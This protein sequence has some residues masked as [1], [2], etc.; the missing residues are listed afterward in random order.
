VRWARV[1]ANLQRGAFDEAERTLDEE[2]PAGAEDLAGFELCAR[3]EIRLGRGDVEGGLLLWRAAAD[4]VATATGAGLW[5]FEVEAVAV[6]THARFGRLDLVADLVTALPGILFRMLPTAPA[7]GFPVCG[8]LLLA[9]A[10][11]RIEEAPAEGVRMIALA[12]RFGLLR[13]FQPTMSPERIRGIAENADGPAYA[14]AVSTYAGL[15]H[16][17][18]RACAQRLGS[19]LN[20]TRAHP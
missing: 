13:G 3:A 19:R 18:L 2:M 4:R 15:D 7:A 1:L 17:G 8:S 14:E 6:L 20:S 5:P 12:E 16:E 9:L 11:T 10:M